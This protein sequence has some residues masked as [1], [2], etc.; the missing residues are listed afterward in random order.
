MNAS[1]TTLSMNSRGVIFV[2]PV[3]PTDVVATAQ[4]LQSQGWLDQLVTRTALSPTFATALAGVFFLR[5]F[6]RR[7]TLPLPAQYVFQDRT[8]DLI[9][10]INHRASGS[11]VKSTDA[12]FAHVDRC[13]SRLVRPT[14]AAVLAREDACLKSFEAARQEG[15]KSIYQLPTAFCTT[16]QTILAKEHEQFPNVAVMD[17]ARDAFLPER[18]QRKHAELAA[19][20]VVICLSSFVA[21]SLPPTLVERKTC[22]TIPFGVEQ[23][24]LRPGL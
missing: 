16:V 13:A 18:L 4:A 17:E 3:L 6:S 19:A 10:S 20:D 15:A 7:P 5:P 14:T 8:A 12:S 2:A 22:V 11:K 23:S 21:R 1:P 9:A 24:W